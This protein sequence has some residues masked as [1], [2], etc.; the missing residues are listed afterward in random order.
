MQT[1]AAWNIRGAHLDVKL[2]QLKNIIHEHNLA[3][4]SI[5]ET[6]LNAALS[7]RAAC[8]INPAW[9]SIDNL[10]YAPYGRILVLYNTSI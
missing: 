10:A 2:D 7:K 9:K 8:Y 4:L 3:L 1:M 5:T 6:K